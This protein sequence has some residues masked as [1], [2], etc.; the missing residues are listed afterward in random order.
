[1]SYLGNYLAI[2]WLGL[3]TST[4]GGTSFIPGR[5]IKIPCATLAQPKKKKFY[6]DIN[7]KSD[8]SWWAQILE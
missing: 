7:Q 5:V 8:P 3:H 4:A 6:L 1:M 2:Q